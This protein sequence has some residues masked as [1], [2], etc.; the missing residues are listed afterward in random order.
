MRGRMIVACAGLAAATVVI[1]MGMGADKRAVRVG[2]AAGAV[3]PGLVA[4]EWGTFTTFSGADGMPRKFWSEFAES[5]RDLPRFV[6]TWH[7]TGPTEFTAEP[8]GGSSDEV[9]SSRSLLALVRM[10]T[11]VIYFNSTRPASVD[12]DVRLE[13][14]RMTEFYPPPSDVKATKEQM[15]TLS[16]RG[17]RVVPGADEGAFPK[18]DGSHYVLARATG[19][20]PVEMTAGGKAHREKFL[21]YRGV[22]DF[23]PGVTVK[24]LGAG[25]FTIENTTG[26][27]VA[28]AFMLEVAGGQTRFM[29]LERLGAKTDVDLAKAKTGESALAEATKAA[30][31]GQG[32]TQ[33]E[34]TAMVETWRTSWFGEPGT[35]L[36]SITPPG[37]VERVL[38]LKITPTPE[39]VKRVF[40]A[41]AEVMTPEDEA[42][43]TGLLKRF[44][45]AMR[46]ERGAER[47]SAEINRWL[48]RFKVPAVKRVAAMS[49]DADVREAAKRIGGE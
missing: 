19:A 15:G 40:V 39:E 36:M 18:G 35:R 27:T 26:E 13:S 8:L 28:A 33:S 17:V 14:G 12:V 9:K 38:P 5:S 11:P 32:L 47:E 3:S 20:A 31:I 46:T 4:H 43:L 10:E 48:G 29:P 16:W 6:W 42:R 24:A 21:F 23:E 34:A 45:T 37:R 25:K 2:E 44:G 7:Q 22:G 30:L 1:A 41:R 49:D